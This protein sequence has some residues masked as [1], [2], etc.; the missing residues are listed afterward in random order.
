M[1]RRAVFPPNKGFASN[2]DSFSDFRLK[3][4]LSPALLIVHLL[5]NE[6][7]LGLGRSR[8]VLNNPV[9]LFNRRRT[10]QPDHAVGTR[11]GQQVAI[12]RECDSRHL[13]LMALERG[14]FCLDG[15]VPELDRAV[16]TA[17]S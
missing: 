5:G 17:R 13:S 1:N 9:G 10:P 15:E 14:C 8:T 6:Q 12:G 16:A 4:L 2:V 3:A 11:R 7:T